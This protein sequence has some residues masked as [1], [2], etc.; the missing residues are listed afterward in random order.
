MDEIEKPKYPLMTF[1]ASEEL[2]AAVADFA[3]A[4]GVS[5]SEV[6]RRVLDEAVGEGPSFFPDEAKMLLGLRTEL[7]IIGRN[8]N[9]VA[10]KV[11]SG[12][13]KIDPFKFEELK[14]VMARVDDVA[15]DIQKMATSRKARRAV[16]RRRARMAQ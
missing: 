16:L 2:K 7:K 15:T 3:E 5:S 12:E 6:I 8:L 11:N 13:V 14:A 4:R 9:Q 1:R 10:R